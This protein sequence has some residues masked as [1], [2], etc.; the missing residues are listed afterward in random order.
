MFSC[1]SGNSLSSRHVMKG[2]P[3]IS[4]LQQSLSALPVRM[5]LSL[6]LIWKSSRSYW[7][8]GEEQSQLSNLALTRYNGH[9]HFTS[10]T[11]FLCFVKFVQI[12]SVHSPSITELTH[13]NYI[14]FFVISWCFFMAHSCNK[15]EK[16][17]STELHSYMFVVDIK[18]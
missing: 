16:I 5:R 7:S 17:T 6:G 12:N 9:Q 13:P 1:F 18:L 8:L 15:I 10:S 3:W 2:L 4:K 11:G 14:F